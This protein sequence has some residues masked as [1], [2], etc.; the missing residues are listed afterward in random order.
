MKF[1]MF[2]SAVAAVFFLLAGGCVAPE[3]YIRNFQEGN[4]QIKVAAILPLSGSNR[5]FAE[6]MRKGLQLAEHDINSNSVSGKKQLQF[7]ILTAKVQSQEQRRRWMKPPAGGLPGSSPDTA[8]MR[9]IPFCIA[10]RN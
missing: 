5:I 9:S 10:L 6:Q 3:L 4:P 8:P 1:K 2:I 7:R